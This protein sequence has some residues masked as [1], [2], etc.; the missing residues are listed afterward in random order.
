[1]QTW[2]HAARLAV[3]VVASVALL[4][5]GT[6]A[7]Q[8]PVPTP[9]LP[10]VPHARIPL[11]VGGSDAS[12]EQYPWVVALVTGAGLPYCG[13]SLIAPDK[14]LTAAHCVAGVDA[15]ELR[16]IAGRTDMRTDQ[17]IVSGV[18]DTWVHPDFTGPLQGDDIAIVTL[19]RDL[20]YPTIPV[21]SDP[22][23]YQPGTMAALFGWGFT[24]EDGHP[25]PVLQRAELPLVSDAECADAY[26]AYDPDEMVCAGYPQGGVD[27]CSGDSGGPLVADGKLIGIVSFGTGCA[28]PGQP[29]V[30]TRVATY[31]DLIAERLS[32]QRQPVVA[33][34]ADPFATMPR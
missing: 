25:S 26:E 1:M 13:G 8:L 21:N 18:T 31:A 4:I 10:P 7:A 28:R 34:P 22:D 11:V 27:A 20:P 16:I 3:A 5:P 33:D 23:A 17:G 14:V 19:D 30:Y 32:S 2:R 9:P 24:R 29:G 12:T 6:A 15:D